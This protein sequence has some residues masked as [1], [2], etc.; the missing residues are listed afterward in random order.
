MAKGVQEIIMQIVPENT[1]TLQDCRSGR[2][3]AC[4]RANTRRGQ[5]PPLNGWKKI[6]I[7]PAKYKLIR[8]NAFVYTFALK[9]ESRHRLGAYLQK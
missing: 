1:V 8:V 2:D 5:S 7:T 9:T 3:S 4:A 6:P